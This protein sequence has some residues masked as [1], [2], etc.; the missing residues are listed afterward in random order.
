MIAKELRSEKPQA[1]LKAFASE[2]QAFEASYQTTLGQLTSEHSNQEKDKIARLK[3][4]LEE[5]KTRMKPWRKIRPIANRN[6]IA[7][8]EASELLRRDADVEFK[9]DEEC[10]QCAK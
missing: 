8:A 7:E 4:Y 3:N 5:R 10:D 1:D 2:I 9:I 6:A